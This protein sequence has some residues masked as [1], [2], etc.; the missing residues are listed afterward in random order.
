MTGIVIEIVNFHFTF[1]E[2]LHPRNIAKHSKLNTHQ[3]DAAKVVTWKKSAIATSIF[4]ESR[5]MTNGANYRETYFDFD[6]KDSSN[7]K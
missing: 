2:Y 6:R 4:P 3:L 5:T 7:D 1:I